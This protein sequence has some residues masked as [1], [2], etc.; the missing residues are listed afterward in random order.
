MPW[1]GDCRRDDMAF[2][3]GEGIR[4]VAGFHVGGMGADGQLA[5]RGLAMKTLGR[6]ARLIIDPAV[7]AGADSRIGAMAFGA[8]SGIPRQRINGAID[9]QAALHNLQG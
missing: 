1:A 6:R 9:M 8:D 5:G 7:A 3:A 2:T 4:N